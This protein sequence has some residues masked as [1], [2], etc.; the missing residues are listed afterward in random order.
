[1]NGVFIVALIMCLIF[2]IGLGFGLLT[3]HSELMR[4]TAQQKRQSAASAEFEQKINEQIDELKATDETLGRAVTDATDTAHT[5]AKTA[6]SIYNQFAE[7]NRKTKGTAD[8][9]E[10]LRMKNQ[11]LIHLPNQIAR[12]DAIVTGKPYISKIEKR[13][14]LIAMRYVPDDEVVKEFQGRGNPDE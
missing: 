7:I 5:A 14:G 2:T 3:V 4:Y 13:D 1:M 12:L 10:F 11:C 6:E 8:D 9:Q